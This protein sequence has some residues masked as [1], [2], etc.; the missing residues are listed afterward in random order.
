M[1]A[2]CQACREIVFGP[3]A[4]AQTPDG[5]QIIGDR[6]AE[7]QVRLAEAQALQIEMTKHLQ[8]RHPEILASVMQ[9]AQ[10]FGY[11]VLSK[12]F[13]VPDGNAPVVVDVSSIVT[14]APQPQSFL[15][16]VDH[17]LNMLFWTLKGSLK[18]T[19]GP[20]LARQAQKAK[21]NGR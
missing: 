15:E 10:Q 19:K 20:D 9:M 17:Q 18:I 13:E 7:R 6:E 4:V 16:I 3:R 11:A 14:N 2:I 5:M 12:A 1:T 21:T 8:A